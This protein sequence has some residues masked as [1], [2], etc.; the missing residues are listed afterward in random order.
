[1]L[2]KTARPAGRLGALLLTVKDLDR[3]ATFYM[4][5]LGLALTRRQGAFAYFDAGDFLL[6]LQQ[7]PAMNAPQKTYFVVF[8]VEDIDAAHGALAA[9]GIE[10]HMPIV[11]FFDDQFGANFSDPDGHTLTI[12]GPRR[13]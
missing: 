12:M 1:M 5:T 2:E 10:F 7:F 9:K 11:P 6:V 13:P 4:D 3:S 8:R